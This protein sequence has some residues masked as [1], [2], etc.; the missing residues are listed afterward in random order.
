[1]EAHF[2]HRALESDIADRLQEGILVTGISRNGLQSMRDDHDGDIA[3]VL[4]VTRETIELLLE[5]GDELLVLWPIITCCVVDRTDD[6]ESC[7][8]NLREIGVITDLG[9]AEQGIAV[10]EAELLV[11]G[12]ETDSVGTDDPG[13][14]GIGVRS[15]LKDA[16][17]IGPEIGRIERR[18]D[19]SSDLTTRLLEVIAED[20]SYRSASRVV[21]GHE[22]DIPIATLLIRP[23]GLDKLVLPWQKDDRKMYGLRTLGS[24]VRGGQPAI[25]PMVT[26]FCSCR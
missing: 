26:C 9:T 11:L 3:P 12:Y 1:V 2:V 10:L 7:F 25:E 17:Q 18:I 15:I 13:P 14:H 24:R 22:S 6:T 21:G 19:L 4:Q 8:A 5:L 23:L 16:L 20:L